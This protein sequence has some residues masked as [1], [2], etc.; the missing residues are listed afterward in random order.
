MKL[1]VS[2][3]N[4][5]WKFGKGTWLEVCGEYSYVYSIILLFRYSTFSS[6][7]YVRLQLVDY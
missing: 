3:A 4:H 1:I 2:T 7:P 5:R 6:I